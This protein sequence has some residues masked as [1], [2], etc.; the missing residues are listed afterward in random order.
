MSCDDTLGKEKKAVGGGGKGGGAGEGRGWHG[1][2]GWRNNWEK[3]DLV[4]WSEGGKG[5]TM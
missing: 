4:D 3:E 2:H 1:E 5:L